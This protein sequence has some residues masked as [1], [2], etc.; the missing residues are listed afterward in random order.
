MENQKEVTLFRNRALIDRS[1]IAVEG[2][3]ALH[4]ERLK[5]LSHRDRHYTINA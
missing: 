1:M 3:A 5:S 2:R 4:L